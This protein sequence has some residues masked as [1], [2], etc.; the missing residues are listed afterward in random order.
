MI[1]T[2]LIASIILNVVTISIMVSLS[3]EKPSSGTKVVYKD[4]IIYKDK[5]VEKIVYKDKVVY[6]DKIVEKIVYKDKPVVH[7][8]VKKE[9]PK[10][11]KERQEL[12]DVLT[13]LKS[14]K[15][16]TKKD[17]ENIYTIEKVLPNV[18]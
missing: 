8:F 17:L 2:I 6:K 11:S 15:K 16:K 18:K 3:K 1:I 13:E 7:Q 4:K 12:L 14:K 10:V 9:E 5:P